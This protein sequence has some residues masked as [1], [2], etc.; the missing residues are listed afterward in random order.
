MKASEANR[1]A[2]SVQDT[3]DEKTQ[4][5]FDNIIAHVYQLIS[6]QAENGKF[7]VMV[8]L[9]KYPKGATLCN[10]VHRRLLDDGYRVRSTRSYPQILDIYWE[11]SV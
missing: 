3:L 11:D 9:D 5:V 8:D 2:V 4:E 1:I 10:R 7:T 6:K